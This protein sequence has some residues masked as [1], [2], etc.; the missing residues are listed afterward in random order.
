[1]PSV[2]LVKHIRNSVKYLRWGALLRALQLVYQEVAEKKFLLKSSGTVIHAFFISNTFISNARLK[3]A[4]NQANAKQHPETDLLLFENY[5][6]SLSM[7][8]SKNKSTYSKNEA[9]QQV[10]MYSW[11]LRLIMKNN[12]KAF[13]QCATPHE[14]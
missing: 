2:W 6:R 3:L 5:L 10:C 4:K 13:P 7:L 14:N 8:P 11:D 1:M 12:N 9:K